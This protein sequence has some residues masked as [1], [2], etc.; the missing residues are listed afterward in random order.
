MFPEDIEKDQ[1]H[2]NGLRVKLYE[3]TLMFVYLSNIFEIGNDS[4]DDKS[5]FKS[6]TW[7]LLTKVTRE[8]LKNL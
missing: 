6:I 8:V 4:L 1:W 7:F 3:F 2:E 5:N